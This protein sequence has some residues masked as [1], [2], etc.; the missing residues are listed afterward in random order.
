MTSARRGQQ[1]QKWEGFLGHRLGN[2]YRASIVTFIG[3]VCGIV[4]DLLVH[5]LLI[6]FITL[7][8]HYSDTLVI[9]DDV[10]ES[11]SAPLPVIRE[12]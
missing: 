2:T 3:D 10:E 6:H 5:N 11:H 12:F 7:Q 9:G 4:N 1:Q 8:D